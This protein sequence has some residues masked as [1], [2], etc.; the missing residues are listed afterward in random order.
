[1]LKPY[2]QLSRRQ[3]IRRINTLPA[4][5]GRNDTKIN[6]QDYNEQQEYLAYDFPVENSDDEYVNDKLHVNSSS[7]FDDDPEKY[8]SENDDESLPEEGKE[9]VVEERS[10][11]V[12]KKLKIAKY[13]FAPKSS[14]IC[15]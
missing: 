10:D 9:A 2:Y 8:Y 11:I 15:I 12:K 14:K 6:I 13:L 3:K 1:M 5:N 7:L 4:G